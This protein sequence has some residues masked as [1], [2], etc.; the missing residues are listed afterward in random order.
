[1]PTST[2]DKVFGMLAKQRIRAQ[3]LEIGF[4]DIGFTPADIGDQ[5]GARLQEFIDKNRY[6][7]MDWIVE[8]ADRRLH[9]NS[10][11]AETKSIIVLG[12]N[13]GPD[14]DPTAILKRE[15]LGAISVYAQGR[16]YHDIVKKRLKRLGRWLISEYGGDI[17][18]FVDT[19]PV[20]EK[21]IAEAAGIGWQGKHT[22]L[23]SRKFGSWL[24][25]GCIFTTLDI[26]ADEK[27]DGGCGSCRACLDA[28]PTNAFPAPYQLDARRCISYLTIETRSHIERELRPLI[29]NRIYGC[30]DCL[31]V[32][33]WN[34][35]A[36]K[37]QEMKLHPRAELMAPDLRELA[38]LDDSGF[39]TLFSSSPVKR[40]GRNRF[41]R[42]VLIAL[43][44]KGD[45]KDIDV[46]TPLLSDASVIVRLAAVWALGRLTS[47]ENYSRMKENLIGNERDPEVLDEW[48]TSEGCAYE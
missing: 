35:Y 1:M 16:D 25:L 38:Q 15:E 30:D 21:P 23:L 17:K 39:R 19:A 44:N 27:T 11:W 32:C 29:G 20:M 18:V 41:L 40:L 24:F 46:V 8:K 34:K 48:H 37:A 33:P 3:A 7:D 4:D 2:S 12:Q 28:C 5:P 14:H 45:R 9:P 47:Q 6:G 13:Y 36:Q 42:N 31:A 10:L 43:G 22:N 26:E